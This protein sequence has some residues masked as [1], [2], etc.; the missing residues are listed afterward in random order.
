MKERGCETKTQCAVREC[1]KFSHIDQREQYR[2]NNECF[3][4]MEIISLDS[5]KLASALT[6]YYKKK[7]SEKPPK[8]SN[9]EIFLA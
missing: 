1:H 3:N 8:K 5:L 2:A 9:F 6:W 4:C 7:G